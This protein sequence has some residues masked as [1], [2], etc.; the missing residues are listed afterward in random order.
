MRK[1]GPAAGPRHAPFLPFVCR[2]QK[3]ISVIRG[4]RDAMVNI[5]L[6][7]SAETTP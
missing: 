6:L 4:T 2:I 1:K 3:M 5:L 7:L